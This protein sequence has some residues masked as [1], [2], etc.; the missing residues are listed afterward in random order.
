M[1][2][3]ATAFQDEGRGAALDRAENPQQ[4]MGYAYSQQQ[5]MLRKVKQ[6]LVKVATSKRRL[7]QRAE[8]L[9]ARVPQ[10]ED[11]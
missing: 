1:V 2:A 5:E 10:L 4:V 6:C 11:Q 3:D 7:Q 9:G 8:K